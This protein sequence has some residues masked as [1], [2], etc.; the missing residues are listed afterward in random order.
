MKNFNKVFN[1]GLNKSGTTS[2]TKALNLLGI[3]SVHYCLHKEKISEIISYN[4]K[5]NKKLMAGLEQFRGF[6][7]F[8]GQLLYKQLD[9]QY[10]NSKFILTVR[11]FDD[12]IRSQ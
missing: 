9:Q 1:I 6:S 7:D 4:K 8:S 5:N 11:D 10:P 12:W 2:L 3:K